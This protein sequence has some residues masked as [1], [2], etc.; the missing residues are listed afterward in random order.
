MRDTAARLGIHLAGSLMLLDGEEA[1]NALLLFAPDGRLWR[2][3]KVYPWGWERG[4][5]RPSAIAGGERIA[6]AQTDLGAIGFLICWDVAHPDL[7][8]RYAGQ[9]DLMVISSCPPDVTNPTYLFPNGDQLTADDMGPALGTVKDTAKLIFGEVIDQQTAWLGVPA[10]CAT[11]SGHITTGIPQGAATL[12][13]L[14]PTAPWLFKYLPQASQMQLSC[15]MVLP[16]C[17]VLDAGGLTLV[18]RPP[19][20]GEGVAIAEVT[21]AAERPSPQVPQPVP[22]VPRLSYLLSD[23]LLPWL[24]LPVYRKGLREVWGK[25]MAPASP[26]THHSV[27]LVGLGIVAGLVLGML[28]GRR[29]SR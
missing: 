26:S 9:V 23:I 2:Y 25:Q 10:V 11:G 5:F 14:A 3:D 13:G 4:Y 12:L 15:D 16:G 20:Q 29:K 17:R 7:W 27:W 21:V 18:E 6:V 19:E 28:L 22:A 24:M 1:Y 8:R